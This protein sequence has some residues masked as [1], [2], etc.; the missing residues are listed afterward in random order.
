MAE[1]II[2]DEELVAQLNAIAEREQRSVEEVLG[3]LLARDSALLNDPKSGTFG[4]LVKSAL[5]MELPFKPSDT[6]E[7]SREIL[8]TEYADYLKRRMDEQ[9]S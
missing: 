3:D 5:E 6:S 1:L 8:N 7:R 2:R 4:M 9:S